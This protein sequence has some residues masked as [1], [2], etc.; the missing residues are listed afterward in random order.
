MSEL[1]TL[2]NDKIGLDVEGVLGLPL[3]AADEIFMKINC[4]DGYYVSNHGRVLA[5]AEGKPYFV[6]PRKAK[7]PS[8]AVMVGEGE[9]REKKHIPQEKLVADVFLRWFKGRDILYHY[10][11]DLT[12]NYYRNLVYVNEEEARYLALGKLDPEELREKRQTMY[13]GAKE[14][15]ASEK[16]DDFYVVELEHDGVLTG[17]LTREKARLT[18]NNM[19]FR[20]YSEK[21]RAKNQNYLGCTVCPEWLESF[22]AFYDWAKLNYYTV[23][24]GRMDLDKDILV[25][26]NKFYGPD[27]CCFVPHSINTLF[28]N[29][30]ASRGELPLGVT[31]NGEQYAVQMGNGGDTPTYLGTYDT[32]EEAFSVYKKHKEALIISTA[33]KF[34]GK[35]PNRVYE[36]MVN[37]KVE[38]T[39]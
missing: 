38:I 11:G 9:K 16:H 32:A 13:K 4:A 36:A 18:Y 7:K 12:N 26:G 14:L 20:C 15:K 17:K 34:K 39:D 37:W 5:F 27:T 23:G 2:Q 35:I 1:E 25:K 3:L 33:D 21:F 6:R 30:G 8:V 19:R 29:S 22:D 24:W 10:D 31:R 28:L